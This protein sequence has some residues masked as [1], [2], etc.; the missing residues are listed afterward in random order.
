MIF[1][2]FYECQLLQKINTFLQYKKLE[3]LDFISF[4]LTSFLLN[5]LQYM[6]GAG[7]CMKTI[8]TSECKNK[9]TNADNKNQH[10]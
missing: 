10:G 3:I 4:I 6:T 9:C 8:D 7:H 5:G 2:K 1:W